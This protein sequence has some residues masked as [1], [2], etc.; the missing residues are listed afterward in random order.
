MT[1][2]LFW[3]FENKC[4][5]LTLDLSKSATTLETSPRQVFRTAHIGFAVPLCC[6]FFNRLNNFTAT[7]ISV[8]QIF[9]IDWVGLSVPFAYIIVLAGSLMTFSSI[10]RKRKAGKDL[11]LF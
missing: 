4:P 11:C 6:L 9:D 7:M 1:A 8:S 5:E 3:D 2:R 10:Y